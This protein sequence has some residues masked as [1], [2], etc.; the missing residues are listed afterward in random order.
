MVRLLLVLSPAVAIASGIGISSVARNLTRSIGSRT[1]F[2]PRVAALLALFVKLSFFNN[3]KAITYFSCTFVFHG[4][5]MGAE[6]Y[7]NPSVVL[8]YRT[9]KGDKKYYDDFRESY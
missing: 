3:F 6:V 9:A 7:S 1:P 2:I 4:S 5:I 8:P